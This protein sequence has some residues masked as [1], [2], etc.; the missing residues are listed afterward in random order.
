MVSSEVFI[1]DQEGDTQ[2]SYTNDEMQRLTDFFDVLI[3]IDQRLIRKGGD[4][5]DN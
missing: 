1:S 2:P 4:F 5:N 3:R